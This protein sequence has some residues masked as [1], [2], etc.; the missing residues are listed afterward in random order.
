MDIHI[1]YTN[2]FDGQ[3]SAEFLIGGE[4]VSEEFTMD[5]IKD[6]IDMSDL[7]MMEPTDFNSFTGEISYSKTSMDLSDYIDRN[8]LEIAHQ[9][10]TNIYEK[11]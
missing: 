6:V 1:E 2:W 5:E 4:Y 11:N 3:L 8:Q 10:I 7:Q 9:L